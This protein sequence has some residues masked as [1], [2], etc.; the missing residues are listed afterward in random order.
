MK[1]KHG[2][3][4]VANRNIVAMITELMEKFPGLRFG[5]ILCNLELL[6][7]QNLVGVTAGD[8]L[9]ALFYEES[10]E[11]EARI[12]KLYNELKGQQ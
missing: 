12:T 5:Q 6:P 3:R 8:Y 9:S 2:D 7:S 11:M 4:L 10:D 1:T